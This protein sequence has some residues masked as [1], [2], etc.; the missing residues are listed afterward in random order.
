MQGG[1]LVPDQSIELYQPKAR[2]RRINYGTRND[3]PASP[4]SQLPARFPRKTPHSSAHIP[5]AVDSTTSLS[6][7]LSH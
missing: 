6:D 2:R 4:S 7:D 1:Q 3:A 5:R